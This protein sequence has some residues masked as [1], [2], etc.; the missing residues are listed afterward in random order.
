MQRPDKAML[1]IADFQFLLHGDRHR[2]GT[3]QLACKSLTCFYAGKISRVGGD[4]NVC[5][6][7]RNK[8]RLAQPASAGGECVAAIGRVNVVADMPKVKLLWA[9]P[10]AQGDFSGDLC[11]GASDDIE[12]Q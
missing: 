11:I 8:Q 6:T 9:I 2:Y 12:N 1:S 3:F 7:K 10:D 5:L 4:N